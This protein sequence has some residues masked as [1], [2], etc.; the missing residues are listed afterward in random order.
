M[1][2]NLKTSQIQSCIII[3]IIIEMEHITSRIINSDVY[4]L[5][6]WSVKK[7][8]PSISFYILTEK[9]KIQILTIDR[10]LACGHPKTTLFCS[11]CNFAV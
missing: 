5:C 9:T 4:G 7:S 1:F 2:G 6:F 10:P 3:I 8:L 11:Q